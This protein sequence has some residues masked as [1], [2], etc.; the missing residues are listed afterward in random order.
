MVDAIREFRRRF[1]QDVAEH[2]VPAEHGLGLVMPSYPQVYD[3]NFLWVEA[4]TVG[5]DE[6]A[7]RGRHRARALLPPARDRVRRTTGT[8]RRVRLARLR[9][10]DAPRTRASARTGRR[11]DTTMVAEVDLEEL[12][13]L[14]TLSTLREPWG[15]DEIARQLNGTA[16]LI[17]AAMPTRYFAAR[18][19]GGD[20]RRVR[21]LCDVT[22]SHRSR[23]SR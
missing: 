17:S 4:P 1:Q 5:A 2:V 22:A 18:V 10:L 7:A 20:C 13:P 14:R 19:D 23:T 11:V 9:A 8:Q 12:L 6:L 15:D 16:R 21:G 3:E